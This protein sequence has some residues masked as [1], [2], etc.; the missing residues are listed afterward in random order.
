MT[1][2][3]VSN[4]MGQKGAQSVMAPQPVRETKQGQE[5]GAAAFGTLLKKQSGVQGNLN[6]KGM[7]QTDANASVQG[8]AKQA[9]SRPV[10]TIASKKD[11]LR[12]EEAPK[13]LPKDPEELEALA[14]E[15]EEGIR[16]ILEEETG[17][18]D[19]ELNEAMETLGL[20]ATDL[21]IP[22]N[23]VALIAEATGAEDNTE[24][25]L[26][27]DLNGIMGQVNELVTNLTEEKG[28]TVDELLAYGMQKEEAP[29]AMEVPADFVVPE[30]K[31]EDPA[32]QT[33]PEAVQRNV[34]TAADM[35]AKPEEIPA[36]R[37]VE[38]VAV[39]TETTVENE[40]VPEEE[41][42]NEAVFD[43][44]YREA[45]PMAEEI[46]TD[47][48]VEETPEEGKPIVAEAK[49]EENAKNE[50]AFAGE[51]APEN[52]NESFGTKEEKTEFPKFSEE[53]AAANMTE[54]N[55]DLGDVRTVEAPE[56]LR[57]TVDP[58]E[59]L[60]QIQEF[61]RTN[62]TADTTSVEMHLNPA[63]LGRILIN[64]S[65]QQ[66]NVTARIETANQ[67]VKEA[68]EA[69]IVNLRATLENA[70]MKVTEVEVTVASHEFERNLEEGNA[71]TG[72]EQQNQENGQERGQR[73]TL[74]SDEL[75]GLTGLMSEEEQLAAR[76]MLDNGNT[77]DARA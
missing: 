46:R 55:R 44:T 39:K 76:I 7:A 21:L 29:T 42:K 30:N 52:G 33:N 13:D 54:M 48:P 26:N 68:L 45:K 65:E 69:Q 4:L 8:A 35:A 5:P 6:G 1:S 16:Q 62:I 67:T 61:A 25:L 77:M 71:P 49:P 20:T 18:T 53:H 9:E 74:R 66:G 23:L 10:E 37:T 60:S 56:P 15:I 57:P 38:T 32:V 51:K 24:L 40:E 50:N 11:S 22:E 27:Q 14:S 58:R 28:I 43:K 75:D 70:G 36:D 31:P 47:N 59:I 3:S 19:E 41:P 64:V 73:R 2:T 12:I 17:L 72:E 63:N 34:E